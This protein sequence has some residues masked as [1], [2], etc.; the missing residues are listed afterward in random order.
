V[1]EEDQIAFIAMDYVPGKNLNN[2]TKKSKL[3]SIPEVFQIT[4]Q[5]ADAL[6]Y[7]HAQ[8][9]I[10]R[11]I[12]PGNILYSKKLNIIKVTDFGIAR[13]MDSQ[14]TRSDIILGSPSYMSPEQL[15][16]SKIDGRSDIFSLGVTFYQLLTGR[17]PF[18]GEDLAKITYKITKSKPPDVRELRPELPEIASKILETALQKST[19]K[20]FQTAQEMA[21]E[22]RKG[23][24]A[25]KNIK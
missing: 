7:A 20:R 1:G 8:N 21:K 19:D 10:H 14:Q 2:F 12:K 9:V 18:E 25:V 17:Y 24:E 11:D 6:D 23:L 16:S 4:A 15:R 5:V 3:L 13:M 22:L